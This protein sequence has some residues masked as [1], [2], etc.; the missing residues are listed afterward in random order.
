MDEFCPRRRHRLCPDQTLAG[1]LA[2]KGITVLLV[3]HTGKN[4][5]SQRGSASMRTCSTTPSCCAGT[6]RANPRTAPAFC[7][8]TWCE[9]HP[10]IPKVC[11]YTFTTDPATD[12]MDHRYEDGESDA[13]SEDDAAIVELLKEGL[14]GKEVA[15]APGRFNL[16][17]Q[18]CEDGTLGRSCVPRS[19][20]SRRFVRRPK[21][22]AEAVMMDCLLANTSARN[23]EIRAKTP[24][25]RALCHAQGDLI[26][27]HTKPAP[28]KRQ[29]CC[30][31]CHRGCGRHRSA[32]GA[33]SS[34][35]GGQ[36]FA[37]YVMS[38]LSPPDMA[39]WGTSAHIQIMGGRT[40]STKRE[41]S[42]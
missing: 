14:S 36:R 24:L 13:V 35:R 23:P 3:H 27:C 33:K 8:S 12:V 30:G 5:S 21:S 18:P 1:P 22:R 10:D 7:W 17:C 32:A 25:S 9:L 34:K 16:C 2:R 40:E 19:N 4:G 26:L 38:A 20:G 15:E 28:A 29:R 11:R 6:N 41:V 39:I 37:H 42:P 31:R